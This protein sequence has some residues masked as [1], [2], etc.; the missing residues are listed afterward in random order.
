M[1]NEACVSTVFMKKVNAI[2]QDLPRWLKV[3]IMRF[4]CVWL[5]LLKR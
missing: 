1:L 5:T 3:L 2:A 4:Y